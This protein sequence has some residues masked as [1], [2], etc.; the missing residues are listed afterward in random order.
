MAKLP[1]G[2][3]SEPEATRRL[4]PSNAFE[5]NEK[6]FTQKGKKGNGRKNSSASAYE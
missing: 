4:E 5:E 3:S 6:R 2:K 1:M